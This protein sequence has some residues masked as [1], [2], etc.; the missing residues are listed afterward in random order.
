M[1][2][3]DISYSLLAPQKIYN[4]LDVNAKGEELFQQENVYIFA[5]HVYGHVPTLS[6]GRF[7]EVHDAYFVGFNDLSLRTT[8]QTYL[9][10]QGRSHRMFNYI[11]RFDKNI[12]DPKNDNL[13]FYNLE[14]ENYVNL[15]VLEGSSGGPLLLKSTTK[16]NRRNF[17]FSSSL[18]SA[19]KGS[20]YQFS[21]FPV[22]GIRRYTPLSYEVKLNEQFISQGGDSA[23]AR[24][25]IT[26]N[27]FS[28]GRGGS[29]VQGRCPPGYAIAGVL[30]STV[31][32]KDG[33]QNLGNFGCVCLPF[34]TMESS[35]QKK[36]SQLVGAYTFGFSKARVIASGSIDV[37]VHNDFGRSSDFDLYTYLAHYLSSKSPYPLIEIDQ[38]N[39]VGGGKGFGEKDLDA[40]IVRK[41]YE[42]DFMM[43]PPGYFLTD[44][45]TFVT[46]HG[47]IEVIEA[48]AAIGCEHWL[49]SKKHYRG[50]RKGYIGSKSPHGKLQWLRTPKNYIA[51]GFNNRSGWL[52]D[53]IQIFSQRYKK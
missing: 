13:P 48:V 19:I 33:T 34:P 12:R 52:T 4:I 18:A 35:F 26:G 37:S 53:Q 32:F 10:P 9:S 31:S 49:T 44:L 16:K 20:S 24:D 29:V 5:S 11:T 36:D 6:R 45:V 17:Y 21:T 2:Y 38:G 42:Q 47:S 7:S 23:L 39:L 28:G 41:G 51:T 1:L 8:K 27:L 30:G 22:E 14:H 40:E 3:N 50:P 46:T 15:R 25:I 43:C